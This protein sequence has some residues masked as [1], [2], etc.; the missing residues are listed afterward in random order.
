MIGKDAKACRSNNQLGGVIVEATSRKSKMKVGCLWGMTTQPR[1][2]QGYLWVLPTCKEI[3]DQKAVA[4]LSISI[5]ARESV[6]L[7]IRLR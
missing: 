2:G 7:G 3:M 6:V 4:R 5:R 1:V